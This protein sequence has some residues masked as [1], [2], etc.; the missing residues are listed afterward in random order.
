MKPAIEVENLSKKFR[1]DHQREPYLSLRDSVKNLFRRTSK[2]DFYALKDINFT[3]AEGE[4]IG[5]I[6]RNGAGKSTLLKIISKITPPTAGSITYRGRVASLLEVGTGFHGELTG[7]ENIFMNGSILGMRKAEIR[8]N[9][10]AIVDF[11]GVEKFIDTPLKHYSSG[12]QL[13]LAFAVAAFLENEILII[14]E[15]LA[16]GD[17]E[18]QKKCI[19]KMDE[20]TRSGRTLLF[21]SHDLEVI[22]QLTRKGILLRDG[23]IAEQGETNH[24]I[25]TY[26][27]LTLEN[28]AVFERTPTGNIP[29]VI[30]IVVNTT[31]PNGV[32]RQGKDLAID[33]WVNMP[34]DMQ[35][36]GIS[37]QVMNL[38]NQPVIYS[39][40]FDKDQPFCR[41]RGVHKL[42]CILRDCR[43][44]KGQY[45]LR[46][47]LAETRHRRYFG[48]L[49]NLCPFTVEM[50]DKEVEWGWQDNVCYY[51][52]DFTWELPVK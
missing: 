42:S 21:V 29:E 26:L 18:F 22:S 13:R 34:E 45:Y 11:A 38:K 24:V 20:V 1:I 48:M 37:F 27:K 17:T 49:D 15:V 46:V 4:S 6:G 5:I 3:V 31:H 8:K 28:T 16:V 7:R 51:L 12:M 41:T 39:W 52:E 25:N 43:L 33:F 50:F 14:D 47:H 2:E 40:M 9:F 23:T 35:N 30:K 19:G 32:H 36:M 10:D 44:Y